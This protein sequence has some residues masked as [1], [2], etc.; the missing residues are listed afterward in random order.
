[1]EEKHISEEDVERGCTCGHKVSV[2]SVFFYQLCFHINGVEWR[3][4]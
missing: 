4:Q 1:M 3:D 2:C